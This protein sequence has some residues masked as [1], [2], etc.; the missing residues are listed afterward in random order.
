[1][2][3]DIHNAFGFHKISVEDAGKASSVAKKNCMKESD[4]VDNN[5][6]HGLAK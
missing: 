4:D 5:Q 3:I 6:A 2:C 1:M